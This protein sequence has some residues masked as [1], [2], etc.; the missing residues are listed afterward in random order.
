MREI[1]ALGLQSAAERQLHAQ[2]VDVRSAS[3]YAAGHLPGAVNIP[4]EQIESRLEDLRPDVPVVLVCQAGARART[5]AGLLAPF[6][7]DVAVLSGGTNAW[8]KSGF[9]LVVNAKT[10]WSLERQVRLAAGL[11]ALAGAVLAVASN[12]RWLYL[13]GFI[14]LGLTFAGLTDLCPMGMV[15]NKMPWNSPR[16]EAA[17]NAGEVADCRREVPDLLCSRR[18]EGSVK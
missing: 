18:H 11:L 9:P 17:K 10:R 15:L 7:A 2:W 3:E 4:M 6:R 5:V 16:R 1:T 13:S 12:P 14:G 8:S